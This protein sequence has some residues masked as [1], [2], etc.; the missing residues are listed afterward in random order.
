[1]A[2]LEQIRNNFCPAPW[3]SLFYNTDKASVCCAHEKQ[4][5]LSPKE[6]LSSDY[7]KQL[8]Q[9]FLA[10]EKPSACNGCWRSEKNGLQS[11]RHNYLKGDYDLTAGVQHMELRASNLCNYACI[12]C[13]ADDSSEIA[14]EV[15]SITE[16]NWSEILELTSKLKIVILTGGEPMLI[17]KYYDL[18]E[19]MDKNKTL[20]IFTNCS[21]YNPKFVERMLEYENV[22]LNL[23]IDG[24]NEIAENQRVGS[25]WTTV[26]ENAIKFARLPIQI[27][28]HSTITSYNILDI[29]SLINFYIEM[30]EVNSSIE[31]KMHSVNFPPN[32]RFTNA[33]KDR[34][35]EQLQLAIG[36]LEGDAFVKVKKELLSYENAISACFS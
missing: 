8:R 26:K 24:V 3:V 9:Q 35:K 17:K 7:V 13:N 27:R 6:F 25:K 20:R 15:R 22:V 33:P 29:S 16:E 2:S 14:G 12:M 34:V 4:L 1:M 32:L 36:K 21:V 18:L 30:L 11:I 19:H 28:I 5:K 10:G 23:S 31:F